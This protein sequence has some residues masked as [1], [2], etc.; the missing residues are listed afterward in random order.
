MSVISGGPLS[1]FLQMVGFEYDLVRSKAEALRGVNSPWNC[2]GDL[3]PLLT[4][5]L[6]LQYEAHLGMTQSRNLL[7]GLVNCYKTKGS[8]A[9]IENIVQAL[10]GWAS[11]VVF[12]PNLVNTTSSEPHAFVATIS[13]APMGTQMVEV[14]TS[15]LVAQPTPGPTWPLAWYNAG[16]HG[17]PLS[18]AAWIQNYQSTA[19]IPATLYFATAQGTNWTTGGTSS[20]IDFSTAI[21]ALT[22]QVDP[23]DYGIAI[24]SGATALSASVLVSI[25][26]SVSATFSFMLEFFGWTT[27]AT[28]TFE[29]L[30]LSTVDSHTYSP[31]GNFDQYKVQNIAVPSG[32]VWAVLHLHML[33]TGTGN[34]VSGPGTGVI[35]AAPMLNTGTTVATYV[36]PREVLITLQPDRE[37]IVPNPSFGGNSTTGWTGTNCALAIQSG[38]YYV[39]NIVVGGSGTSWTLENQPPQASQF[40]ITVPAGTTATISGTATAAVI[41]AAVSA[42]TGF[43]GTCTGSG[44]P[45]G[46]SPVTLTFSASQASLVVGQ[47]GA[48]NLAS[49]IYSMKVTASSAGS[50]SVTSGHMSMDN[51]VSWW[52]ASAYSRPA[53]T[54]RNVSV[55]MSFYNASSTLLG[56][57]AGTAVAEALGAWTRAT[58]TTQSVTSPTAP[59]WTTALGAAVTPAQ[60][61]SVAI[62]I[63][64]A[65][66]ANAEIHYVDGIMVEKADT[67]GVYFDGSYYDALFTGTS[68]YQW[69]GGTANVGPSYYYRNF[70][71]KF[72][73][74]DQVLSGISPTAGITQYGSNI[75]LTL[76]AAPVV[77]SATPWNG[78]VTLAWAAPTSDGGAPILGYNIF[79]GPSSGTESTTPVNG[80][81]LVSFSPYTV[82]DLNN[83]TPYYF[84]IR[85]VTAAGSSALSNEVTATPQSADG[86]PTTHIGP[87]HLL[88][89]WEVPG[90]YNVS[91]VPSSGLVQYSGQRF[92]SGNGPIG[93]IWVRSTVVPS[94]VI[95]NA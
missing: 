63:T 86:L 22:Q 24:P 39:G 32:A 93:I 29:S 38:T 52:S 18:Y 62:T 28:P 21:S 66:C 78:Q 20:Y 69:A 95:V 74:L 36:P 88:T 90:V 16:N 42:I 79:M 60:V 43:S 34:I 9:G 30:G 27:G 75:N 87:G 11:T 81:T 80:S 55:S 67:P 47:S 6:G 31:T 10:T 1:R 92:G 73:R 85:A 68:D 46:T 77:A 15:G 91:G 72:K 5:E 12:G 51:A 23:I 37:N 35:I 49:N 40:T 4:S 41:A 3:L 64:W 50:M 54:V 65:S 76:P 45:L 14:E 25:I 70:W 7:A 13:S 56:T 94:G 33:N 89:V 48:Q 61:A 82:T 71:T 83:T 8:T 59:L 58:V 44:G 26:G 17:T 84:K 2:P 57:I 19:P 53:A